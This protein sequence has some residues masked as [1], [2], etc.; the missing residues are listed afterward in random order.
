[1]P[2]PGAENAVNA[3]LKF[4]ANLSALAGF[5]IVSVSFCNFFS[6]CIPSQ[7]QEKMT[8]KLLARSNIGDIPTRKDHHTYYYGDIA[9]VNGDILRV[10]CSTQTCLLIL[11]SPR[12][13][14]NR[15]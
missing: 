1:M 5:Y 8:T 6:H 2:R 9:E 10:V 14:N 15:D 13:L 12:T 3:P 11:Q 4:L 7:P